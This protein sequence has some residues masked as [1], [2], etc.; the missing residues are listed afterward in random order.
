MNVYA[1][2]RRGDKGGA[3][4]GENIRE[5]PAPGESHEGSSKAWPAKMNRCSRLF[6]MGATPDKVKVRSNEEVLEKPSITV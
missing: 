5:R 4:R 6:G 1:A 2:R 3:E